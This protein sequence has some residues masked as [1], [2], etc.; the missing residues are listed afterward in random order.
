MKKT[1]MSVGFLALCFVMVASIAGATPAACTIG[2]NLILA[3]G[4]N[5]TTPIS[6]NPSNANTPCTV[7]VLTFQNFS[8]VINT[9]SSTTS[10]PDLA[11]TADSAGPPIVLTLNPNLATG[12]DMDVAFQVVGGINSVD[13]QFAE[14]ITGTGFVNETVCTVFAGPAS[15]CPTQD[16]LATLFINASGVNESAGAACPGTCTISSVNGDALVT[17]GGSVGQLWVL[18]DLNTGSG[19]NFSAVNESFGVPEPMTLSLLGAGLLGLGLLRK[20]MQK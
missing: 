8:Y 14:S 20:R 10:P 6:N 4:G 15:P 19:G 16:V 11:L 9:G 12:S 13:L 2:T 1:L 7:G 18:K 17:F 5:P 3:G